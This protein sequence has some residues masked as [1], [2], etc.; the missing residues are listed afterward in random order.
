[1]NKIK[2]FI[3]KIYH[4]LI[5]PELKILPGNIAFFIVL[6]VI[7][8]IT[9]I[10]IISSAVSIP[11]SSLE[12]FM[13][14]YLPSQISYILAPYFSGQGVNLNVIIFTI[15][16]FVLAS[17]GTHAII[18][19]TNKLYNIEEES[20]IKRRIK[21]FNLIFLLIMLIIFMLLFLAFGG[22]IVDF[23]TNHIFI[24]FKEYIY[25]LYLIIKWPIG[26][27]F[28]FFAVKIIYTI[29]PDK[30]IKSKT[31]NKGAIFTTIMW[32]IV[33]Y[34]YGYYVTNIANYNLFYGNLSNIIILMLWIY[35]IS[36]ILIIGMVINVSSDK[37]N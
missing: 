11:V 12:N 2:N 27:M 13:N 30:H 5:R 23:L 14:Q 29:A 9:L 16:G 32:I 17:N 19:A 24:N 10:G 21:A 35:I 8:I 31:V 36:Y 4:L 1:M 22:K 34:I 25:Y 26:F 7:P 20:S 6:S 18:I 28:I 3:K 33:T 37:N 15:M